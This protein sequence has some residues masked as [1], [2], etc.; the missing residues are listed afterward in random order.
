MLAITAAVLGAIMTQSSVH[1]KEVAA[2]E[3]NFVSIQPTDFVV[4]DD[5]GRKQMMVTVTGNSISEVIPSWT[6]RASNGASFSF[7]VRPDIEGA[8]EFS[9]GKWSEGVATPDSRTSVNDQEDEYSEVI[10]DTFIFKKPVQ[11]F[12]LRVEVVP[13]EDGTQP[14]LTD[15]S[16]ILT[17]AQKKPSP[18]GMS[19]WETLLD[20]PLRAQMSYEGGGVLCSPTSVSMILGYWA[21]KT[22]KPEL[23]NDVP[24]VQA[25]VF[26]PAW[27][28]T[29]NW[30]FNV[31]FGGSQPGMTGYVT[32]FRSVQDIEAFVGYGVP[33]ATS[34]SYGL[35]KGIG[36]QDN[37]GHL[38]VVVGFDKDGNPIFNDPG[39]NVVR[40]TYKRADFEKAWGYSKNTVYVIHPRGW[41]IP[42]NGPWPEQ[43][44]D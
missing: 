10:T 34:V 38:V 6:G 9:L 21:K 3:W 27:N 19:L 15:M 4:V 16:F 41:T 22:S 44:R 18:G 36:K 25:G 28:G 42:K 24:V 35:L 31:A 33:I 26:D 37:D 5:G 13:A 7:F 39:R 43:K 12:T 40:M 23:D 11:K 29:G 14:E 20:V 32:R 1:F 30:P 17:G 2:N 8:K